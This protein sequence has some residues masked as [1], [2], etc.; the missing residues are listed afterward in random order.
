MS[1]QRGTSLLL[2]SPSEWC[3]DSMP[4]VCL[5]VWGFSCLSLFFMS[6][7]F[8]WNRTKGSSGTA[9][10]LFNIKHRAWPTI[11]L[12]LIFD[13]QINVEKDPA[14][15]F[16]IGISHM[17]STLHSYHVE[18]TPSYIRVFFEKSMYFWLRSLGL[19]CCVEAF[20]S[21]SHQ[22]LLPRCGGFSCCGSQ[23]LERGP[24]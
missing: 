23:A 7:H 18:G 20:S 9:A 24:H 15:R 2:C 17:N 16:R 10:L 19:Y 3:H 22:G 12:Q 8:I 1:L 13:D 4:R 11:G 6:W 14:F 5:Q 21:G